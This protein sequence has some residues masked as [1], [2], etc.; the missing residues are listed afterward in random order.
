MRSFKN[1]S[2]LLKYKEF[3]AIIHDFI[4]SR[5]FVKVFSIEN[6]WND[7]SFSMRRS[8]VWINRRTC[9]RVFFH[10]SFFASWNSWAS[11]LNKFKLLKFWRRRI[12]IEHSHSISRMRKEW[13]TSIMSLSSKATKLIHACKIC[14]WSLKETLIK[15][16]CAIITSNKD[17]SS[18]RRERMI[19]R[20]FCELQI[21]SIMRILIFDDN[22]NLTTRAKV[23]LNMN[24]TTFIK[25]NSTRVFRERITFFIV[26]MIILVSH[27]KSR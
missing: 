8:I 6:L 4:H 12:E 13:K 21:V 22:E 26:S 11:I 3:R 9:S 17:E 15:I 10:I 2:F 7:I 5:L 27:S 18:M 16:R 25:V 19:C 14:V 23:M 1:K 24:V 20:Q